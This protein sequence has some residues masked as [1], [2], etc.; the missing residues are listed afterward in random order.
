MVYPKCAAFTVKAQWNPSF[1]FI[2]PLCS[3][4]NI[5]S[6]FSKLYKIGLVFLYIINID[7]E[8][9]V[10]ATQSTLDLGEEKLYLNQYKSSRS[11]T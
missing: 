5:F 3:N 8:S 1:L 7:L 4:S 9:G 2:S 10:K 11:H 6:P